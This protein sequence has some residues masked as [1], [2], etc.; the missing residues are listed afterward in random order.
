MYKT[1]KHKKIFGYHLMIDV[2]GCNPEGIRSKSIIKEFIQTL[3]KRI[4]MKAFGPTRITRFGKGD[5]IGLTV[6]QLIEKSDITGHFIEKTNDAYFDI[7]SCKSF[8][9]TVAINVFKEYFDPIRIKIRFFR[10]QA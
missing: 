3:V 7:F 1:R 10:R 8:D 9:P 4:H 5:L 2:A 6:V